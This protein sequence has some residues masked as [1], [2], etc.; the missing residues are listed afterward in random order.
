LGSDSQQ[1]EREVRAARNQ[2]L[3]R[4]INEK[5]ESINE[6]FEQLTH[7]FA[8]ACECADA[9]CVE[10]L[11]IDPSEYEAVRAE[12]RHFVVLPGHVYD[13]VEVVVRERDGYVVVE[14]TGTAADVAESLAEPEAR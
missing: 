5:I 10:M 11:D 1:Q 4:S 6:A 12:P 7:T 3:F 13:E 14:K 9:G 8:I 2:A